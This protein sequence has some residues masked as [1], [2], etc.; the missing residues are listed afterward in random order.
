LPTSFVWR[1]IRVTN[2]LL[3]DTNYHKRAVV[4]DEIGPA[5]GLVRLTFLVQSVYT[6]V[7]RECELTVPQAQM[8]CVLT[9]G[10]R[11]MAD[12][13][14]LLGVE[15]SSMTGLVDRAERCGLVA[16]HPD[17]AD[18]RGVRVVLTKTG[19][20]TVRRFHEELSDRLESLLSDLSVTDRNRFVRTMRKLVTGVPPVFSD[21]R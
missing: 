14:G 9:D 18:R 12:L 6:D 7:G 8:L 16:R 11:G 3:R 13:S 5:A 20:R 10:P 15:K 19:E 2:K 4:H 1:N 17:P 21:A